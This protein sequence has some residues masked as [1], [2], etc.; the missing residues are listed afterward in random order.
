MHRP[1]LSGCRDEQAAVPYLIKVLSCFSSQRPRARP[2]GAPS[3]LTAPGPSPASASGFSLL[4]DQ[5]LPSLGSILP[6]QLGYD[7][8]WPLV[9]PG[10]A[11]SLADT[12]WSPVRGQAAVLWTGFCGSL[13]LLSGTSRLERSS[14]QRLWSAPPSCPLPSMTCSPPDLSLPSTPY[15][16]F[17]PRSMSLQLKKEVTCCPSRRGVPG[18]PPHGLCSPLW[19]HRGLGKPQCRGTNV[20]GAQRMI[21]VRG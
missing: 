3:P 1:S 18:R 16:H 11:L 21:R 10:Q 20:L 6:A 2:G 13:R 7:L 17:L 8:S 4:C 14:R 9:T 15:V 19:L 5:P 12:W